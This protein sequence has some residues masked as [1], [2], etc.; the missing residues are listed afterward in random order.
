MALF[1]KAKKRNS[2]E[3]ISDQRSYLYAVVKLEKS[4]QSL[5]VMCVKKMCCIFKYVRLKL[6]GHLLQPYINNS[7]SY[8]MFGLMPLF[9]VNGIDGL[10]WVQN[11]DS[12]FDASRIIPD[13][14]FEENIM[15]ESFKIFQIYFE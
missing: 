12:V 5:R 15:V 6:R 1:N 8:D 2:V 4:P 3:R 11:F 10:I 13:N 7:Q 14:K 9:V